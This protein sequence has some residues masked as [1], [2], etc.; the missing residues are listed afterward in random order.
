MSIFGSIFFFGRFS[1]MGVQKHTKKRSAKT[2]V[3]KS[4]CKK[5]EKI[6][7]RFFSILLYH[8]FGRFSAR[9]VQID[10]QKYRGG[11][12]TLVLFW[13]LTH[14]PTTGFTEYFVWCFRLLLLALAE[15]R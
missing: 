15:S 3:S 2:I 14:S 13:P 9:G 12:M 5:I 7:N 8:V 4:F 1:A 11:K 10:H 6:Q